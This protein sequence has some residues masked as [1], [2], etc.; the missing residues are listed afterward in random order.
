MGEITIFL[1]DSAEQK[2]RKRRRWIEVAIVLLLIP[3]LPL[4]SQRPAP[5]L[6]PFQIESAVAAPAID[7][8]LIEGMLVDPSPVKPEPKPRH[9]DP[10]VKGPGSVS[11]APT[12]QPFTVAPAELRFNARGLPAQ[13]V[14][15]NSSDRVSVTWNSPDFLITD[16]CSGGVPCVA[17]VV[18]APANEGARDGE[19]LV[20]AN[21]GTKTVR[22]SGFTPVVTP[23]PPPPEL[24]CPPNLQPVTDPPNIHFAGMGQRR[25]TLSNP[26]PCML[27]IDAIRLF[28]TDRPGVTASGYKLLNRANCERI[29]EPGERCAF[30]VATNPWHFTPRATIDVRSTVVTP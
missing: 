26:H 2:R 20:S 29:L 1:D 24:R 27:R 11:P 28:D 15:I 22:L 16:N 6:P 14:A 10:P 12:P 30:D 25:V 8:V 19:L 13:L 7:T 3:F 17:A 23:P 4:F 5:A 9:D 18:F 21:G